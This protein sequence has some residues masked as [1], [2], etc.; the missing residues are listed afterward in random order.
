MSARFRRAR[1]AKCNYRLP[2]RLPFISSRACEQVT[3]VCW[4]RVRG[5]GCG[6]PRADLMI[7]VI[8]ITQFMLASGFIPRFTAASV[9]P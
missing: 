9:L 3:P 5:P 7:K 6:P 8:P 1:G 2:G 4:G